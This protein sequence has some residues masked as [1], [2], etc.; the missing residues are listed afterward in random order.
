ML[1]EEFSHNQVKY[2][3]DSY[4][5]WTIHGVFARVSR[6][7]QKS[8]N[9]LHII[10]FIRI[11]LMCIVLVSHVV[12]GLAIYYI[13]ELSSLSFFYLDGDVLCIICTLTDNDISDKTT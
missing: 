11:V 6:P 10:L 4:W 7:V 8:D 5:K 3:K 9:L 12:S 13:R 1:K 2:L